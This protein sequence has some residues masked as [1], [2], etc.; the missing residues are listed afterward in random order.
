[1]ERY[2]RGRPAENADT[3]NQ[4]GVVQ[5]AAPTSI[6][7][8]IIKSFF[9][10]CVLILLL[11]A[12]V[13]HTG[14]FHSYQSN[15]TRCWLRCVPATFALGNNVQ[16]YHD[17]YFPDYNVSL[18]LFF[19]A[20]IGGPIGIIVGGIVS[21]RAAKKVGLQARAWV[22]AL[23]QVIQMSWAVDDSKLT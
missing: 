23:S 2:T 18:Y 10:P 3:G 8:D 12:C 6:W 14:T 22:L 17:T 19:T 4:S 13:K 16:L 7:N 11:A 20:I 1:M 21:D 9:Q 5:D 15:E